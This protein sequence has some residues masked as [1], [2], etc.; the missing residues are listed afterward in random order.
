MSSRKTRRAV[1][2]YVRKGPMN[3]AVEGGPR[4]GAA[5]RLLAAAGAK[6]GAARATV[7]VLEPRKLLF[8]LTIGPEDVVRLRDPAGDRAVPR[9]GGPG[10]GAGGVRGRGGPVDGAGAGDPAERHVLRGLEHPGVVLELGGAGGA[11]RGSG[12]GA[13]ERGRLRH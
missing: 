10:A 8:T 12:P 13:G 2:P 6:R 1:R 5:A 11:D 9:P 3:A 7:D 4:G